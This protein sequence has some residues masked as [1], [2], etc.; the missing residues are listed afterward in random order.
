MVWGLIVVA[1]IAGLV[2]MS[3]K[4]DNSASELELKIGLNPWIGNG[5]YYVAQEKGFFAQEGLDIEIIPYED[6]GV[7]KQLLLTGKID[8]LDLTPETAVVLADS[9]AK[10]KVIG[11]MDTSIGADGI[12]ATN[13]IKTLADLKGKK[14]AFENGSPSHLLL[15]YLLDQQGLTTKDLVEVNLP[16]PDAGAS[17]VSGSVE[18][19]VTWEPWLSK[20][21]E[22]P[23]GLEPRGPLLLLL[24]LWEHHLDWV[25]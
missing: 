22:R 24:K 19:A 3:Q 14:V 10:I 12:I 11:M 7:G 4:N 1:V 18:A 2:L 20:A 16:A 8:V 17:F 13:E 6:G 21:V 23:G 5:I 25:I 9:G 15:S